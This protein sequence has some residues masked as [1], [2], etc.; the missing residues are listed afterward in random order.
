MPNHVAP[1]PYRSR[2]CHENARRSLYLHRILS[3][4]GL[5]ARQDPPSRDMQS[6]SPFD[7]KP[8]T[9]EA[10]IG[11]TPSIEA[12]LDLADASQEMVSSSHD[13][14]DEKRLMRRIDFAL[15]PWLAF[16]FILSFLDRSGIGNARVSVFPLKPNVY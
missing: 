3:R 7:M 4:G 11:K 1:I 10:D 12:Q 15:L 8:V 13:G 2:Q 6:S 9:L 16:L 14:V 5:A